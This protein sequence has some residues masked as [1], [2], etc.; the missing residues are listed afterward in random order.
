MYTCYRA[1]TIHTVTD[2]FYP[3]HGAFV[4][5]SRREGARGMLQNKS[6]LHGV[7]GRGTLRRKETLVERHNAMEPQAAVT[8]ELQALS[9]QD[10]ASTQLLRMGY[11]AYMH[12]CI[13]RICNSCRELTAC[14]Y[15]ACV[16]AARHQMC[17]YMGGARGGGAFAP[18][19]PTHG[20]LTV[21]Q[22]LATHRKM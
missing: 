15:S 1:H 21:N 11:H 10:R 20:R 16:S 12:I 13:Y 7:D 9:R 14:S 5:E 19:Q 3:E 4:P 2:L 6:G 18:A 8:G 22:L 17:T